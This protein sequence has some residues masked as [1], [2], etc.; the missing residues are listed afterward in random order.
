[1]R[2]RALSERERQPKHGRKPGI[3]REPRTRKRAKHD[4][5]RELSMIEKAKIQ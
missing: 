2:Q 3:E 5:E 1:M 4:R